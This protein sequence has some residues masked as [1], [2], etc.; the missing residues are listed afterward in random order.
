MW[1]AVCEEAELVR[2]QGIM[3]LTIGGEAIRLET[4]VLHCPVCETDFH[5]VDS[6]DPFKR[7]YSIARRLAEHVTEA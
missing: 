6:P 5:D 1:C 3:R 2:T 4:S 7:A